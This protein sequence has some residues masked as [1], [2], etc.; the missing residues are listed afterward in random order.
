MIC[1]LHIYLIGSLE[2]YAMECVSLTRLNYKFEEQCFFFGLVYAVPL[3]CTLEDM[4]SVAF[5]RTSY[6]QTQ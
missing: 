5:V 1:F 2:C 4:G 6:E 3:K